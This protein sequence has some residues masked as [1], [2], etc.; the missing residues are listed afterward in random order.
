[1]RG[2]ILIASAL[3]AALVTPSTAEPVSA[4]ER[5]KLV[6]AFAEY[7][8]EPDAKK[9]AKI[10]KG[11]SA[12]AKK[13]SVEETEELIAEAVP[14]DDWKGG[15]TDEIEFES[16]GETWTYSALLPEKR[17]KGRVPL[18]LDVGHGSWKD[19]DAK[20][21][22]SGMAGWLRVA[23]CE[24]DVVYIR[25][26]VI[27]KLSLEER[28]DG[29]TVP[30]RR[31]MGDENLDV[32]SAIVM[33]AV[34]DACTRYPIDPDRVYVQGISQT[35]YWTWWLAQFAPDRWAAAAP[36]GAVTFH[37]RQLVPNVVNVPLYV[38]HG[39][40]DPTCA[41]AQ[42]DGMVADVK[43]AGGDVDFRP[44]EGGGHMDGVFVRFGEIWPEVMKR[45]RNAYPEKF[46]RRI[47]SAVRP[48]AFW[49]RALGIE[50]REFNPWGAPCH[51][52]GEIDGQTLKVT[53]EG[54][55]KIVVLISPRMVDVEKSVT[56]ELNGKK[57]WKKKPKAD[58][59]AALEVARL[60]GDG[61]AFGAVVELKAD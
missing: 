49:L 28:Y 33:D 4:A 25:T 7:V 51:V 29:Y 39:T 1:M 8:R 47:V 30:P 55:E 54:C 45:T 17:P 34:R 48:D 20:Q 21:R 60:R 24:K 5:K 15:F 61:A 6:K 59:E 13:L 53:A 32:L 44:T 14:G 50:A 52:R 26:R 36:V 38:L 31:P 23:G 43:K 42:A 46:E 18:V 11:V 56:I 40:K 35:G 12:A 57:V 27:D 58:P 19:N 37:V 3:L 10:W 9:R 16:V 2:R 22:E 41:F